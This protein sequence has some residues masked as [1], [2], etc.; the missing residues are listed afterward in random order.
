MQRDADKSISRVLRLQN[1]EAIRFRLAQYPDRNVHHRN[2][3]QFFGRA[4]SRSW[5]VALVALGFN[6]NSDL[7]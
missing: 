7:R 6:L 1:H 2:F 5:L 4:C 3:Y